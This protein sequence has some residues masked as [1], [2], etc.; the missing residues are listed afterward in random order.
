[1]VDTISSQL[2]EGT[3]TCPVSCEDVCC[4]RT[5]GQYPSMMA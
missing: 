5:R 1:M 3:Y 4:T 2:M